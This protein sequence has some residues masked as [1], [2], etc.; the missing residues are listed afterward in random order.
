MFQNIFTS[1]RLVLILS[2]L[3]SLCLY[4][5]LYS[6]DGPTLLKK[7]EKK[8]KLREEDLVTK[9]V[10]IN[11]LVIAKYI[12]IE[13][14]N[15]IFPKATSYG[16]VDKD[17]LSIPVFNNDKEIGF[18]F[19]TFDVTRG[20]G[21]S[22]RPFNLAVGVDFN[23]TLRGVKLL[24]HVEPIAILGRTDQDFIDY[25]K[26]Y[27]DINLKS[28]ISL[29]LKLTGA[30]IEGDNIAMRETAG[31]VE[32]LT[33]IDGVSRTTTSSLLFMDAIMRGARKIARQK[34]IILDAND[35]GNFVDLEKYKPQTWNSLINDKSLS[36]KKILISDVN[37]AFKKSNFDVPRS[38]R[39][40]K[41]EEIFTNY[42]IANVSPAGIGTNILGRRWFDQYISAGRNVDDQVYYIAFTSN[43]WRNFE[44]RISQIIV[45]E[46]LLLKQG[47]NEIV[48]TK[49]LFKELPFNH[50]KEAPNIAGQGL[51]YLSSKFNINPQLPLELVYKINNQQ[52]NKI[53]FYLNYELPVDYRLKSFSNVNSHST[54]ID[55]NLSIIWKNNIFNIFLTILTVL[56][57]SFVLFFNNSL[58]KNRKIFFYFRI[59]FLTWVLVWLGWLIGGQLSVIHLINIL[60]L[61]FTL[62]NNFTTFLIEPVVFLIGIFTLLSLIIWG[63]ALFCGW[64]CPFG[65]LQELLSIFSKKIG[66]KQLFLSTKI[67]KNFR[68]I[69]YFLLV[70]IIIGTILEF[71]ITSYIYNIEPFKTAITLRFMAPVNLVLWALFLLAINLLVERAYCRYLCPLGGGL[72]L[73][74]QI[75][76]TNFLKR[77]KECGNPC[78]ACNKVCPTGAI[79]NSGKIN[80]SECLGCLDCQVMYNDYSKCP[81]L[82]ALNRNS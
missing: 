47:D 16:E 10:D 17:T 56:I 9:K 79:L 53:K 18:L 12:S 66:I 30:D 32:N 33:Q 74:G 81:P 45:K 67:D 72:A 55:S 27:K 37:T 48:V 71:N 61:I 76:L 39:F 20:L 44:T 62:S 68:Y 5:C 41:D 54:K 2:C 42:Y 35:M 40:K 31:E 13:L 29:T 65:A 50:A 34:G 23:G 1:K 49:D 21:Y 69:K 38:I 4:K 58:T 43:I 15:S 64:L 46:N 70:I 24:K 52:D 80:M 19:E 73:L 75:R 26:Q 7:S 78:K 57:A 25:L 59:T 77:R 36:F 11:D 60:E 63:R 82:V 22:R 6:N 8:E 3:L 14:V 28:G 51:I